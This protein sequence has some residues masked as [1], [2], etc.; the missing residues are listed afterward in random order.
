MERDELY[1]LAD[2][3]LATI[4]GAGAVSLFTLAAGLR[5]ADGP[6]AAFARPVFSL[7]I[8]TEYGAPACQL[9]RMEMAR[10]LRLSAMEGSLVAML[11]N[12][13]E[14]FWAAVG[15]AVTL[16]AADRLPA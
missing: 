11:G 9:T 7:A 14:A 5:L 13:P 10:A 6:V 8:D 16:I 12:A 4:E 15:D 2:Q 3:V 1:G